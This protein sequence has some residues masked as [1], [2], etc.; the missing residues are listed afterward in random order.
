MKIILEAPIIPKGDVGESTVYK[1]DMHFVSVE[2]D[3]THVYDVVKMDEE[4][5]LNEIR[6][7]LPDAREIVV[8]ELGPMWDY[9]YSY[10]KE[11]GWTFDN[12]QDGYA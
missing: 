5:T 1:S 3:G 2:A 9:K 6:D 8:N 10:N 7:R 12:V 11:T 4:V